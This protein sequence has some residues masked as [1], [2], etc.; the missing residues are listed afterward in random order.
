M[1]ESGKV[2][3]NFTSNYYSE[4]SGDCQVSIFTELWRLSVAFC[5]TLWHMSIR[6]G[7]VVSVTFH[8]VDNAPH[9]EAGTDGD[10]Q[11]LENRNSRAKEFHNLFVGTFDGDEIGSYSSHKTRIS[12]C[13]PNGPAFRFPL[14]L[15]FIGG[16]LVCAG[17]ICG[18]CPRRIGSSHI[19]LL[20]KRKDRLVS[21]RSNG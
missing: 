10:H 11:G 6:A 15:F 19:F 14:S 5:V 7:V 21:R 12:A 3:S 18:R 16:V 20:L 2:H 1:T 13:S 8:Q 4:L 17:R 9:A